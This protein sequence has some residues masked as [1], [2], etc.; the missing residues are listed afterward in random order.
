MTARDTV[1]NDE[2]MTKE[3]K[4]LFPNRQAVVTVWRVWGEFVRE[5]LLMDKILHHQGWW[6]SH[7]L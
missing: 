1:R 6:L 3:E 7:C 5:V 4:E 2:D